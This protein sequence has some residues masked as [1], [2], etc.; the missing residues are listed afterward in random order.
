MNTYGYVSANPLLKVDPKGLM[1]LA[2]LL[3]GG[4][5][6]TAGG[7]SGGAIASAA[8]NTAGAVGIAL[9]L[10]NPFGRGKY[11]CLIK[12]DGVQIV[13]AGQGKG[14]DCES[15]ICPQHIYGYGLGSTP[16]IAWNN[17]WDAANANVPRGCQ[18]RH[19]KGVSGSCKNWKGGKR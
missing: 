19:C 10:D 11:T 17:A 3:A 2:P 13:G 14:V 16:N 12:C 7:V 6:T 18:K 4:G 9:A 15:N 1:Q 5:A 8:L